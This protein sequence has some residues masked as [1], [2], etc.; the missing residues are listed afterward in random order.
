M[1]AVLAFISAPAVADCEA[2][3]GD[4]KARLA[5]TKEA[6]QTKAAQEPLAAAAKSPKG[7]NEKATAE[8]IGKAKAAPK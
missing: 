5:S 7:T 8:Q 1:V 6:A 2:E 3:L 4:V